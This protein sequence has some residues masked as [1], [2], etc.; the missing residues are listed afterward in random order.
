MKKYLKVRRGSFKG[1]LSERMFIVARSPMVENNSGKKITV[2]YLEK[3][4]A[5]RI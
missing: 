5:V 4:V 1:M 3:K 2:R